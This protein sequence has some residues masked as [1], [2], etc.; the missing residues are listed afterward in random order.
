LNPLKKYVIIVAGGQGKR[1][2][3][4]IPKQFINIAGSPILI[5]TIRKFQSYDEKIKIVL[6]LPEPFI[7]FWK[8]LTKRYGFHIEHDLVS[9]GEHRFFSVKN[10]LRLIPDKSLV[11]IH[12]GVRPM[13]SRDTIQRV[14]DKAD[15]LGNAVP[16]IKLSDSLRKIEDTLSYPLKRQDYRLVQTPQCFRCE[17][18]KKAYEQD[19]REEFTDDATVL[20]ATGE[21]I[22][23]VDGNIENIKITR[24]A[25]LQIAETFLR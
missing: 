19:Y 2:H 13:V 7:E 8:S 9:G 1:M 10:G 21:K 16:V 18:L 12:D 14:F 24:P 6:V 20:E 3:R 25:D 23:L 15:K 5:H 17:L 11:A 22:Y 4:D